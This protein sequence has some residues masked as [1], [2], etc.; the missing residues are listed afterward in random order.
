V[1]RRAATAPL[2]PPVLKH[3]LPLRI[4]LGHLAE[5]ARQE[6]LLMEHLG[7]VRELADRPID[8]TGHLAARA[9]AADWSRAT[10]GLGPG[11]S[12]AGH[13]ITVFLVWTTPNRHIQSAI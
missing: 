10:T 13:V 7:H 4:R 12:A 1:R 6:Q 2:H 5:P 3:P 8:A 11:G 9:R